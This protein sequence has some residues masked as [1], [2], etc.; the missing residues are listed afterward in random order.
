MTATKLCAGVNGDTANIRGLP[1]SNFVEFIAF[2][3]FIWRCG[4]NKMKYR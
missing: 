1:F 4:G 3:E 2:D